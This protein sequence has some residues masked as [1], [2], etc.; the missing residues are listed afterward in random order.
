MKKNGLSLILAGVLLLTG[1]GRSDPG[2]GDELRWAAGA[3]AALLATRL[4]PALNQA[5]KK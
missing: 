2:S 1:A 3:V 5:W 4:R